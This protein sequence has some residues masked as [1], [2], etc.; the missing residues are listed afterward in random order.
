[1]KLYLSPWNG[2]TRGEIKLNNFSFCFFAFKE[3]NYLSLIELVDWLPC[4]H[5]SCWSRYWWHWKLTSTARA[6]SLMTLK[7]VGQ[8]PMLPNEIMFLLCARKSISYKRLYQFDQL[9][10]I[11]RYRLILIYRYWSIPVYHFTVIFYI[12]KLIYVCV[13]IIINIK[14][15]HKT[16]PQFRANYS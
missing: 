11:F 8:S 14:V 2:E 13:Y 12:Y 1:M 5:F 10:D 7:Q 4:L 15:Y 16:L 6:T 3:L 9:N